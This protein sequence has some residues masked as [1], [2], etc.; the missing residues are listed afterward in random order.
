MAITRAPTVEEILEIKRKKAAL[1]DQ[2]VGTEP[3]MVDAPIIAPVQRMTP[4]GLV[5]VDQT[6]TETLSNQGGRREIQRILEEAGIDPV[7]ELIAAYNER[8]DDPLSPDN[9]K[10]VMAPHE[11]RTLMK[12]MLKYTHPQ[13]KAVEHT[14][15][16]DKRITVV[17]QMPDGSRSS[18]EVQAR[19]KVIDT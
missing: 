12:E 17:L 19:G 3:V 5:P 11:R 15:T 14:G 9:G 1:S 4:V 16:D 6:P 10:F 7:A 8:V 2:M 13:L 18:Q